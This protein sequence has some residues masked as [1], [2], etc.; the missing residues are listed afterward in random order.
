VSTLAKYS[1]GSIYQVEANVSYLFANKA[2]ASVGYRYN[3]GMTFTGCWNVNDR[4]R[5]GYSYDLGI[6]GMAKYQ[7]GSHE[8]FLGANFKQKANN[9][10]RYF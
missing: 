8:L 5:I 6:G 3:Y 2:W 10:I 9:S 4:L 1:E 7:S